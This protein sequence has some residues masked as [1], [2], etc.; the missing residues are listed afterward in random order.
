MYII[1][2]SHDCANINANIQSATFSSI[3]ESSRGRGEGLKKKKERKREAHD[4][5]AAKSNLKEWL[6]H[7]FHGRNNGLLNTLPWR[8][9]Q[10]V[11]WHYA[12][13]STA[14]W[15]IVP[16]PSTPSRSSMFSTVRKYRGIEIGGRQLLLA[17]LRNLREEAKPNLARSRNSQP[18]NFPVSRPTLCAHVSSTHPA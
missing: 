15:R 7:L 6:V 2:W 3:C 4:C 5:G 17:L 16:P 1:S 14:Q 12:A 13:L 11:C 8:T 18:S 10:G 9:F